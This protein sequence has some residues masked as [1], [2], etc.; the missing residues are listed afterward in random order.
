MR[1]G[2]VKK[3]VVFLT[4]LVLIVIVF[5]FIISSL[6]VKE[7]EEDGELASIGLFERFLDIFKFSIQQA[8]FQ[9][10]GN[11]IGEKCG[12]G[13]G[14]CK[15]CLKCVKEG[16]LI[17]QDDNTFSLN[18]GAGQLIDTTLILDVEPF[19][20]GVFEYDF[21]TFIYGG[22]D[23]IDVNHPV[24]QIEIPIKGTINN[25]KTQTMV[26]TIQYVK[27]NPLEV[28]RTDT[29]TYTFHFKVGPG[30]TGIC[31]ADK[32]KEGYGCNKGYG[33]CDGYGKCKKKEKE[34]CKCPDSPNPCE[35]KTDKICG[36]K[37]DLNKDIE[38]TCSQAYAQGTYF[39]SANF[40]VD[41]TI[42]EDNPPT[43]PTV[44]ACQYALT[45]EWSLCVNAV[46]YGM[47]TSKDQMAGFLSPRVKFQVKEIDAIHAGGEV[48]RTGVTPTTGNLIGTPSDILESTIAHETQHIISAYLFGEQMEALPG[49]AGS[50]MEEG[51]STLNQNQETKCRR[52][53]KLIK[54]LFVQEHVPFD[55]ILEMSDYPENVETFYA[56]CSSM[57]EYLY[58][59]RSEELK[60]QGKDPCGA[61]RDIL[62]MTK[63]ASLED[64]WDGA[65]EEY[66][67]L[68][69]T[70]DF[71]K[72]WVEYVKSQ[73]GKSYKDDIEAVQ[74]GC[75]A[76][77]C[78]DDP[79]LPSPDIVT[80]IPPLS[81]PP[82]E[83]AP[84][85]EDST[86]PEP[87][88]QPPTQPPVEP[89][90]EPE[91]EPNYHLT[92]TRFTSSS[93]GPC[94]AMKQAQVFTTITNNNRNNLKVTIIDHLIPELPGGRLDL[95]SEIGRLYKETY[96]GGA[97]PQVNYLLTK[98]GEVIYYH[99]SQG[100][101][102]LSQPPVNTAEEIQSGI[103]NI[104]Q[105][106]E[107]YNTRQQ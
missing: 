9:E 63:K 37:E 52:F 56:Q 86:Y 31:Q 74:R 32:A 71:E 106:P 103:N 30:N 98:D 81:S 22:S 35:D 97:L 8:V 45:L 65:L 15:D 83:P 3:R 19:V 76:C 33:L 42:D 99:K 11:E 18:I 23:A 47:I 73:L 29:E 69:D 61:K 2:D 7:V 101:N 96:G 58:K 48:S 88:T 68:E 14:N 27:N 72:E 40:Q 104:L 59:I 24:T 84:S 95:T 36:S 1:K 107:R 79:I 6:S 94:R 105:N 92:I 17:P 62:E 10:E 54:D 60:K 90:V 26:V 67:G 12:Y 82:P 78:G 21:I 77:T 28:L 102:P 85:C 53:K 25:D 87:P 91:P 80:P 57:V 34:D 13:Y 75:N 55:E 70:S 43:E 89:P 16:V 51:V 44:S 50:C 66:F 93:C 4:I 64:D 49:M 5:L 46:Q 100:Y 20:K 39:G 38:T 41:V